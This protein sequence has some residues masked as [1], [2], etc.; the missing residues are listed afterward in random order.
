MNYLVKYF[1]IVT[2]FFFNFSFAIHHHERR[3]YNLL[4]NSD[5]F[6]KN[7]LLILELNQFEYTEVEKKLNF[8]KC[9]IKNRKLEVF[10]KNKNNFLNMSSHQIDKSLKL[11][12]YNKVTLIGMDGEIK[13]ENNIIESFDK[14]FSIIDKMPIR[15]QEM[16]E[17]KNCYESNL[18]IK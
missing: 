14:Y 10:F 11:S 2:F 15:K 17:D 1:A 3:S 7:R 5:Y 4:I 13:Y 6:W 16:S 12:I 18:E 8:Y 9:E